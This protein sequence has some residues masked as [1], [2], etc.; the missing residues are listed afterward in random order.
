MKNLHQSI[1]KDIT[2]LRRKVDFTSTSN[3][4]LR[5]DVADVSDSN[6]DLTSIETETEDRDGD[7]KN[8]DNI[9]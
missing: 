5:D 1:E 6:E 2:A 8:Q 7:S 4:E 3:R 9:A